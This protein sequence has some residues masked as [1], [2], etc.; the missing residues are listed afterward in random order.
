[1]PDTGL[2]YARADSRVRHRPRACGVFE[3]EAGVRRRQVE[4]ELES[5]H[6]SCSSVGDGVPS[7]ISAAWSKHW[8]WYGQWYGDHEDYG[9]DH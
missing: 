2:A 7:H 4:F 6:A 3:C 1:M 5:A 8:L 9:H